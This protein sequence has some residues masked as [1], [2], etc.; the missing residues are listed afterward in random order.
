MFGNGI[1]RLVR[2]RGV[3]RWDEVRDAKRTAQVRVRTRVQKSGPTP[4]RAGVRLRRQVLQERVPLEEKG[5]PPEGLHAAHSRLPR[6]M[7]R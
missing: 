7:P 6:A 1:S 5:V 2:G 4:A 3:R